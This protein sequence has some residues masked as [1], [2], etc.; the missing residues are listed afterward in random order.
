MDECAKCG[1]EL[2]PTDIFCGSCGNKRKVDTSE[3]EKQ[4]I[5]QVIIFYITFLVYSIVSYVI[6]LESDSLITEIVLE[7]VF[8]LLTIMFSLMD[9]SKILK[10]YSIRYINWKNLGFSIVFPIFTAAVVYYGISW[11]NV[12]LTEEDYN[13]FYDYMGYE[14]SFLWAFIFIAI[15]APVFE[16]LAFRGYLFNQLMNVTSARVTIIATALIFALVHFSFISALWIFPFGLVLGYLRYK[17]RT[18]WLGMLMHFIHN[19]L[20]LL[21]DYYYFNNDSLYTLLQ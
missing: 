17:Y 9:F 11:L 19:F 2:A 12:V 14:N 7:S 13:M 16:E 10:L 3:K 6:Y 5:R 8:V 4:S 18:L 21:L 20:V 1:A 15:V